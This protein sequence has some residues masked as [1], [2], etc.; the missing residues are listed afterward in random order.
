MH[1]STQPLA[2]GLAL[3]ARCVITIALLIF[4]ND[5]GVYI[6]AISY[7]AYS[8]IVVAVYYHHYFKTLNSPRSPFKSILDFLPRGT[9]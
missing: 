2:E 5:L 4:F 3:T 1:T 6:F 8:V 9:T 7:I